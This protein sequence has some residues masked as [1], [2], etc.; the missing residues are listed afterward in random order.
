MGIVLGK[1]AHTGQSVQLTA[2]LV[3]VYGTKLGQAQRKVAVRAGL[4]FVYLAVV[5][6]V[7]RFQQ[8]LFALLRGMYRL[9]RVFAVFFVVAAGYIKLFVA[10]VRSNY[11]AIA[12]FLLGN[13]KEIYQALAQLGALWQPQWQAQAHLLADGEQLQ[14]FTD[15]TVVALFSLFQQD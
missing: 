13:L 10:N 1:A 5:R 6:A 2:L 9:K 7:H 4:G 3:A 14:L 11:L 12:A 8:V 15:F